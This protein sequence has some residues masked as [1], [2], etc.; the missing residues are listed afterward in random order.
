VSGD[1]TQCK[2]GKEGCTLYQSPIFLDCCGLVRQVLRD[3]KEEFGFETGPWN[4]AYQFDTLPIRYDEWHLMKP[5]D[6]VFAEGKYVKEGVKPQKG[7]IVHVEVCVFMCVCARVCACACACA[8]T[9]VGDP[10]C[11]CV[12]VCVYVCV[13]CV[14]VCMCVCV[15]VCIDTHTHTHTHNSN[16]YRINKTYEEVKDVYILHPLLYPTSFTH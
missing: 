10:V 1:E 9:C 11:V 3:L 4:Q 8:C 6:L 14:C 13:L 16:T 5:G 12:C 2:C 7:D 15:G